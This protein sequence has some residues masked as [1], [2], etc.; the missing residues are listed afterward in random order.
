M[1][2]IQEMVKVG[3]LDILVR[4]RI[5]QGD[6]LIFFI[7]G[8]GCNSESFSGA[9]DCAALKEYSLVAFDLPGFGMSS[10]PTNYSYKMEEQANVCKQLLA[11]F[12][13]KRIHVVAH[14]VGGAIGL[15]LAQN[16]M[17]A[18]FTSVEGNLIALD[19]GVSRRIQAMT[20]ATFVRTGFHQL[21]GALSS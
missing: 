20:E 7:H 3:E 6:D 4:H 21:A 15:I 10:K 1:I 18:S 13:N 14:S 8:L 9:W 12:S 2:D 19:C 11:R 5:G 17:L 16:M